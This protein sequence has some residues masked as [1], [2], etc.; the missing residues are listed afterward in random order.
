MKYIIYVLVSL[1]IFLL[2]GC[3]DNKKA[4]TT[5]AA[6]VSASV[7]TQQSQY[8]TPPEF[9]EHPDAATIAYPDTTIYYDDGKYIYTYNPKTQERKQL[10]SGVGIQLSH[11]KDRFSYTFYKYDPEFASSSKKQ[12]FYIYNLNTGED[13]FFYPAEEN[14]PIGIL[15]WSPD[16]SYIVTDSGTGVVRAQSIIDTQTTKRLLSIEVLDKF[17]WYNPHTIIMSEKQEVSQKGMRPVEAAG[18]YGIVMIDISINTKKV[19]KHATPIDNYYSLKVIGENKI[20]YESVSI[21]STKEWGHSDDEKEAYWI[22]DE[23]GKILEEL[24]NYE[25]T[26]NHEDKLSKEV[27]TMLPEPYNKYD[28]IYA[29]PVI[30]NWVILFADNHYK[31]M[32]F[33][34]MDKT[35]PHSLRKIGDGNSITW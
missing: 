14:E 10:T 21:P 30:N 3:A 9:H 12:G 6:S 8:T 11:K 17:S 24:K 16:D 5:Q 29:R 31:Y 25:Q 13:K 20:L 22:M 32:E 19:L 1:I 7:N 27:K 35:N 28:S 4:D 26:Y 34:I 15:E 33:F 2:S 18:A 23:N